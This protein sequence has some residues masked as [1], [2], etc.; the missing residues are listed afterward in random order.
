MAGL[1]LH[2]RPLIA[3]I[4]S[5]P[6][7]KLSLAQRPRG[8]LLPRL[9]PCAARPSLISTTLT[10]ASAH[11]SLTHLPSPITGDVVAA[12]GFCYLLAARKGSGVK[13]DF[14]SYDHWDCVIASVLSSSG[15]H[16]FSGRTL[17]ATPRSTSTSTLTPKQCLVGISVSY[18]AII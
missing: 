11:P 14:F 10:P 18:P 5:D 15:N 6:C 2:V 3:T 8:H 4:L 13:S 1:A 12:P 16:K 17:S 9:L 7:R